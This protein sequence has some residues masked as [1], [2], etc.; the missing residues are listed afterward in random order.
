MV[1]VARSG[2]GAVEGIFPLGLR[3]GRHGPF[4]WRDLETIGPK[5]LDFVDVIASPDTARAVLQACLDWLARHWSQWDALQLN[6][7]REDALLLRHVRELEFPRFVSPTVEPVGENQALMIPAGAQRWEDAC[8]GEHRRTTRRTLRKLD[9]DG[10]RV[11]SVSEGLALDDALDALVSLHVR[12]RGEFGETSRLAGVDRARFRAFVVDAVQAG[13]Y[14]MVLRRGDVAVAA[15]LTLRLGDCMSHYRLAFDSDY[16]KWS[17]GIGLL[18]AAID[19]AAKSGVREYDF[20]FGAEEYK[21]RWADTQR[22]VYRV[23]LSNGHVGRTARRIW[24][25]GATR[26]GR[27]RSKALKSA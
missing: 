8:D 6:P 9:A 24:L 10:F 5:R 23:Q 22:K 2:A 14:L 1:L 26:V 4:Q 15:L 17:P 25:F 11:T 18:V 20:G 3:P 16:S 19:R 7:V 12:R 27:L 21:R 13:G